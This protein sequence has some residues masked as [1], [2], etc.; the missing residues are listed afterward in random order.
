VYSFGIILLELMMGVP[1]HKAV[2]MLYDDQEFFDKMEAYM[3]ARA[4]PWPKKVLAALTGVAQHCTAFR[5]RERA[6]VHDVLPKIKAL[7][8]LLQC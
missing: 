4:G 1:A 8:K 3:D 6:E 7:Q 5:P 2:E